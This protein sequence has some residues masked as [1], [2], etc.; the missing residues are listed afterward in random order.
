MSMA[1]LA[2]KSHP[3]LAHSGPVARSEQPATEAPAD[4]SP[5]V[6]A[7]GGSP[8]RTIDLTRTDRT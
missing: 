8:S 4:A 6:V 2:N 3:E 7:A 1:E 5:A